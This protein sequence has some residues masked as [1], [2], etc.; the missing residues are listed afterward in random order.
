MNPMRPWLYLAFGWCLLWTGCATPPR[1]VVYQTS[2]IDALLAG[3]YD[4]DI[5][6][7]WLAQHGDFG[8]GTFDQLDGEMIMLDATLYQVKAD[9]QV[10]QPPLNMKTPFATVCTF[11]PTEK[12]PVPAHTDYQGLQKLIDRAAPLSNLF[13][14]V[15]ITGEFNVMRTR[16]VPQQHQ[17]YLP[18]LQVTSHQPEFTL[19]HVS[20]TIV[21]FRCPPYTKGINVPG[22]HLHFLNQ[23]RT[24]G[25]HILSFEMTQ[26]QCELE[27]LS[28]YFLR[29][30][31]E[32]RDFG[33]ADLSVDRSKA[34]KN[35]ESSRGKPGD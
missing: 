5:S 27:V 14:A 3:V 24:Q 1:G 18:L 16:S 28:Q 19:E 23:D 8:I 15:K 9:G 17:P 10:Y 34:L 33:A 4:G 20:G 31:T 32:V 13:C 6:C 7:R 12:F 29:L 2:T 30:P 21:G 26:G 35:V 25:G 22:Y 11:Q